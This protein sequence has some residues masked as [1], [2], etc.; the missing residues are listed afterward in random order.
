MYELKSNIVEEL[1]ETGGYY[2]AQILFERILLAQNRTLII[3]EPGTGKT[4]SLVLPA[5]FFLRHKT[6]IKRVIYIQKSSTIQDTQNQIL[7]KCTRGV[8][9]TDVIKNSKDDVTRRKN[10]TIEIGKYY[11]ILSYKNFEN[12]I[13]SSFLIS[14]IGE[15]KIYDYEGI[16]NF[17]RGT[18][19]ICDEAHNLRNLDAYDVIKMVFNIVEECCIA[20]STASP[21]INSVQELTKMANLILPKYKQIPDSWDMNKITLEQL[22]YYLSGYIFYVR[23]LD[24]G[25]DINYQGFNLDAEYTVEI[26]DPTW[27]IPAEEDLSKKELIVSPMIKRTIKS[28]NILYPTFMG[29]IQTEAYLKSYKNLSQEDILSMDVGIKADEESDSQSFYTSSRQ[30]SCMVFPDG[31]YNNMNKYINII[32]H[33]TILNDK[34]TVEKEYVASPELKEYL[35]DLNKLSELSGIYSQIV[36]IEKNSTG[37]SFCFIDYVSG[38]GAI[39]LGLCLEAHGFEKFTEKNSVFTFKQSGKSSVCV[40][41]NS[42]RI[43]RSDFKKK[44]RYALL[45]SD[46]PDAVIESFIE[47]NNSPQNVNGEYLQVI[48]G[49]PKARDGLNIYHCLRGHMITPG[50]HPS[51]M[52]QAMFRFIRTTSHIELIKILR[53]KYKEQGL[54]PYDARINVDVYLH[55]AIPLIKNKLGEEDI[56]AGS[57]LSINR[58]FYQHAEMKNILIRNK[59][60]MLKQIDIACRINYDRNVRPA[61]IE[62]DIVVKPGDIDGTVIC[63]YDTCKYLCAKCNISDEEIVNNLDYSTYNLFYSSKMVDYI[64]EDIINHL[65]KKNVLSFDEINSMWIKSGIYQKFLVYKAIDKLIRDKISLT[66]KYGFQCYVYSD[67]FSIYT[68]KEFPIPSTNDSYQQNLAYYDSQI[69]AFDSMSFIDMMNSQIVDIQFEIMNQIRNLTNFN[70]MEENLTFIT[71]LDKLNIKYLSDLIE[72]CI[73]LYINGK[74]NP[75]IFAVINHYK[76][77]IEYLYEPWQDIQKSYEILKN[78]SNVKKIAVGGKMRPDYEFIGPPPAGSLYPDGTPVEIVYINTIYISE[79]KNGGYATISQHKNVKGKYRIFKKSTGVFREVDMAEQLVYNDYLQKKLSKELEYYNK[80][81]YYGSIIN[82]RFY[83]TSTKDSAGSV[84][85]YC[86]NWSIFDLCKLLIE[87]NISIDNVTNR[88]VSNLNFDFKLKEISRISKR[89]TEDLLNSISDKV[90]IYYSILTSG[91][92]IEELCEKIQQKF[93][94]NEKL[95]IIS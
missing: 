2:K 12:E 33:E 29:E 20:V 47:L 81:K 39:L 84:G 69:I 65:K 58:I 13:N 7:C 51:G 49:S 79:N 21:M 68:Q 22:N 36:S 76:A 16:I 50:W 74:T 41:Q 18:Y 91:V 87:E 44:K 78:K 27:K 80:F 45:T 35:R 8:Y 73:I 86:M 52:W 38:T 40:N 71:L 54:N 63:D 5:E 60:R 94:E 23:A 10:I 30:I 15:N 72:E 95:Q 85:K 4:C 26:P 53:K 31:S 42:D 25:I 57:K 37:C 28:Q 17:F 59:M 11:N 93:Y 75:Y 19:F 6:H 83:I 46:T 64:C 1:P 55:C 66:D 24:T 67:N 34:K 9:E 48:I 90:D 82:K 62:E 92:K 3:A 70:S 61:Q 56:E 43:I 14:S 77:F 88:N 89:R 32:S